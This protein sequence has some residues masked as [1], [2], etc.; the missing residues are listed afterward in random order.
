MPLVEYGL[1]SVQA[2]G[3]GVDVEDHLGVTLEASDLWEHPTVAALR[4]ALIE[5]LARSA[6]S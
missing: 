6:A 3:I 1:D 4:S 5:R 2:V